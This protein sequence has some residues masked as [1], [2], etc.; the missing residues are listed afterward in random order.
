MKFGAGRR[1]EVSFMGLFWAKRSDDGRAQCRAIVQ[2]PSGLKTACV[3]C[4]HQLLTG[5]ASW[6]LWITAIALLIRALLVIEIKVLPERFNVLSSVVLLPVTSQI[7]L[8]ITSKL[9]SPSPPNSLQS[10]H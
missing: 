2:H 4:L 7:T 10:V 5:S 9:T 1:H 6:K 8:R 3:Q